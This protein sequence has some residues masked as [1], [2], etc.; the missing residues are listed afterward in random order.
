MPDIAMKVG[1][2]RPIV[3]ATISD[4]N[5]PVNL[6]GATVQF[7]MTPRGTGTPK[8]NSAATIVSPTAGTVSYSWS[9]TDTDTPGAY[10]A[11]FRAA[12]GDGTK[13]TFPNSTYLAVLILPKLG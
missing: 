7:L 13:C 5:G 2:L 12:M 11:E 4:S 3:Q 1:D 8:V 10:Y 6:T 9:T